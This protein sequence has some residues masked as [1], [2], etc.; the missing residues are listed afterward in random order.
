MCADIT[1][2]PDVVV[3]IQR[4]TTNNIFS[5]EVRTVSNTPLVTYC[6]L[7]PSGLANQFGCPIQTVNP[8]SWAGS[9]EIGDAASVATVK[10]AWIKWY[11]SL[12]SP[13]SGSLWELIPADLADWRFEGS[14][15]E[16]ATGVVATIQGTATYAPKPV[17]PPVCVA[18][19]SHTLRAGYQAQLD[20]S[21][22]YPL[23]GGTTLTYSWQE[24]S[25]PSRVTWIGAELGELRPSL[26]W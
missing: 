26:A 25:G 17:Y 1:G 6:G 7:K 20:G 23:D 10:L 11:S 19:P 22:S 15:D 24:L 3:R 8:A 9:G 18:G 2:V 21:A 14:T 4:D 16:V 13:G 12:V 5:Y